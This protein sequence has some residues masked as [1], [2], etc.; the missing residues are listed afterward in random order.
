MTIF[1]QFNIEESEKRGVAIAIASDAGS[2]V[3]A[4]ERGSLW[5]GMTTSKI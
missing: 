5:H 3:A 4:G 1:V 2:L